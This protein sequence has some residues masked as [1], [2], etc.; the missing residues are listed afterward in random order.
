ME[1]RIS[2]K[3]IPKDEK[4][5]II[6]VRP[7]AVALIEEVKDI[8]MNQDKAPKWFTNW[9]TSFEKKN[10]ERWDKQE[11]FNNEVNQKL[12]KIMNTPTMKK[13]LSK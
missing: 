9:T 8:D 10:D 5:R 13:E 2:L 4:D 11:K 1:K 6:K 3:R 12:D 7:G